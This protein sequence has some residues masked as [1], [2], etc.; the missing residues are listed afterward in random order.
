MKSKGQAGPLGEDLI[1]LIVIVLSIAVLLVAFNTIYM[2]YIVRNA[3]LSM[4]RA[5]WTTADRIS[6]EWAY[7]DSSN[8]THSRLLDV[9]KICKKNP[10][11]SG[12]IL[13]MSV[14]DLQTDKIL[15]TCGY[16]PLNNTKQAK[17]P[18]ALRF[19]HTMI[20]PGMLEVRI[21][22]N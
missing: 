11:L 12:Y 3:E 15:C 1:S 16:L 19:N 17:L 14:I 5:A 13:N 7:T 9:N 20:H 8:V 4:Y 18:V 6:T 21:S 10:I 22:R 2:S